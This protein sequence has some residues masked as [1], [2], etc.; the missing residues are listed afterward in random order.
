MAPS[1]SLWPICHR[2]DFFG[3]GRGSWT[4]LTLD[5]KLAR[6][7][8]RNVRKAMPLDLAHFI[9]GELIHG[10][11]TNRHERARKFC[12]AMR[13]KRF[14]VDW[15]TGHNNSMDLF[16][17]ELVWRGKYRRGVDRPEGGEYLFDDFRLHLVAADV[18]SRFLSARY[19]QH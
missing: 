15:R 4:G 1:L 12:F 6:L 18:Q 7:A 9:S 3:P 10:D 17:A 16:E 5:G 13:L 14:V 11:E 19:G 8:L 2:P